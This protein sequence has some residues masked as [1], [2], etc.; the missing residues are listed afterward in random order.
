MRSTHVTSR[1]AMVLRGAQTTSV[2]AYSRHEPPDGINALARMPTG[3]A[4]H[5][6]RTVGKRV[7]MGA[8]KEP[9][10]PAVGRIVEPLIALE[11]GPL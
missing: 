5:S 6:A 10:G 9:G 11:L 8:V 7:P 1:D 4:A 3:A 2:A